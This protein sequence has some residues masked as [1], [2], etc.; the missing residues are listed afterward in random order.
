[1]F[2]LRRGAE[3]R[4]DTV[5]SDTSG[6]ECAC[7]AK[8]GANF[9]NLIVEAKNASV[10][11]T[12]I[13][14]DIELECKSWNE[15]KTGSNLFSIKI[16][17]SNEAATLQV[18]CTVEGSERRIDQLSDDDASSYI[19]LAGTRL[20][21]VFVKMFNE[22]GMEVN[23]PKGVNFTCSW[24]N[25]KKHTS[26]T[27]PPLL[28]PTAA[29]THELKVTAELP[30]RKGKGKQKTVVEQPFSVQIVSKSATQW[31][32]KPQ[33][34]EIACGEKKKLIGLLEIYA[35]D[36]YGNAAE[37]TDQLTDLVPDIEVD[38]AD[39]AGSKK[40]WLVRSQRSKSTDDHGVTPA[41]F[42]FRPTAYVVG[43]AGKFIM[44]V[45][46]HRTQIAQK[47]LHIG[48][49]S[50]SLVLI[51]GAPASI[52]L[53]SDIIADD[54]TESKV[55]VQYNA[56]VTS[57]MYLTDLEAQIVDIGGN[58]V[59]TSDM[60]LSVKDDG[61]GHVR[62]SPPHARRTKQGLAQFRDIT[63]KAEPRTEIYTLYVEGPNIKP[64]WL[65]CHVRLGNHVFKLGYE[66]ADEHT[67][68]AGEPLDLAM[69]LI[70]HTED[71]ED[72]DVD[73]SA[74]ELSM[75]L[76]KS[77]KR[78]DIKVSQAYAALE[79]VGVRAKT[80]KWLAKPR[81][82][83][84]ELFVPQQSGTYQVTG[85][86]TEIRMT[87]AA[88]RRRQVPDVTFEI[89]V[90]PGPAVELM[91]GNMN[92]INA[93]NARDPNQRLLVKRPIV[94]AVDRFKNKVPLV[95]SVSVFLS[96]DTADDAD[97]NTPAMQVSRLV[98][99]AHVWLVSSLTPRP[100]ALGFRSVFAPSYAGRSG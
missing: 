76:T 45:L 8:G 62:L 67:H 1:M 91:L 51:A 14:V 100:L 6:L 73:A 2:T 29:G 97:D 41:F 93:S 72:F 82:E 90:Q 19:E 33:Q 69:S 52:R 88:T 46:E 57:D 86:Y 48:A 54:P 77:T 87:Q 13:H 10:L 60:K 24:S 81:E 30:R 37:L 65:D 94:Y 43:K 23:L 26:Q 83:S 92:T 7:D 38:G 9:R 95:N 61:Q 98:S 99:L 25:K 47:E 16:L 21:P 5:F 4:N 68:I 39:L 63:L 36:E 49:A 18:W 55:S 89:Q 50:C 74:F 53:R 17:P 79:T 78:R 75:K 42:E 80:V 27:M 44:T 56:N 20:E 40:G 32:I 12:E 22:A 11:N 71:G 35:A 96:P 70:A 31:Q 58:E 3:V 28:L 64:A 15:I 85:S 59:A 34:Q 66:L 84:D